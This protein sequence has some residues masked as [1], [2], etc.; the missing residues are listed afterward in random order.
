MEIIKTTD[1][2][3]FKVLLGNRA[4]NKAHVERL[5]RSFQDNYLFSPIIVNDKFEIIDGRHRYEAAKSL[6]L[7]I[8]YIICKN[9]GLNEVQILNTNTKN[10]KK[11][12]YLNA[13]CDMKHPEYLKFR[14]FMR[15]YPEFGIKSVEYI[16][17][18][19]VS[20]KRD[21]RNGIVLKSKSFEEGNLVIEDYEKAIQ[22][23]EKLVQLRH[24]YKGYT[25]SRFIMAMLGIFK[26]D[27]YNHD[28]LISRLKKYP[29]AMKDCLNVMQYK[30]L[31]E[32]IY[33]YRSKDKLSLRF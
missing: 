23:A 33:N 25:N 20:D 14:N 30:L 16:L 22:T 15:K 7:P 21:K 32:D 12:D 27:G 6:N 19:S 4:I 17:T 13:Y 11:E 29:G 9:Y 18:N 31:I 8:S 10:W 28:Q 3:I 26:I 24:L 2:S 1:Y 5:R